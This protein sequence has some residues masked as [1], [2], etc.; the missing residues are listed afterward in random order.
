MVER[1]TSWGDQR[2]SHGSADTDWIFASTR[3]KGRKPRTAKDVSQDCLKPAAV[4]AGVIRADYEGRFGRHNLRY[5]LATFADNNVS[6][7]M[8]QTLLRD[9]NPATTGK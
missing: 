2:G 8:I 1:S 3:V 6:F 7:P 4:K 9:T 5:S